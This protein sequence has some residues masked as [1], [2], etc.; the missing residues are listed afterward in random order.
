MSDS[1]NKQEENAPVLLDLDFV[2]AWARQPPSPDPYQNTAPSV[3]RPVRTPSER[4][5]PRQKPKGA[6]PPHRADNRRSARAGEQDR[7]PHHRPAP[8]PPIQV[9]FVPEQEKL[10][11]V[12][13]DIRASRLAFPLPEVAH[14]FLTHPEWH[15]VKFE[16]NK[17]R[18][19][20]YA[21]AFYQS[22]LSGLLF[23]DH[24]MALKDAVENVLD[25]LFE[26][27]IQEREAPPGN[28]VCVARCRLSG[29]LLPPTNHHDH[30]EQVAV[31]HRERFSHM[32]LDE[33]RRQIETV[34]DEQLIE[35]WKQK[36]R[37][38]TLY[39]LKSAPESEPMNERQARAYA[40]ENMASKHVATV[41][42][43]VLSG[44]VSRAITDP[45][46]LRL[47]R[48]AWSRE[49]HFPA[50]LI[51]ALRAAFHHMNLHLFEPKRNHY[52]VTAIPP[53]YVDPQRVIP[54]IRT[55]L[56]WLQQ[57]PGA[58]RTE[59]IAAVCPDAADD[60]AQLAAVLQPLAWLI[61]KGHVIE[62]HHGT[63]A[64]PKE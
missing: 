62:F 60:A 37:T 7:R 61:E 8:L 40:T 4:G 42:R 43:A 27:E 59:L 63:L 48:A 3:E 55:V 50:S 1:P 23:L 46:L 53:H 31:L 52:F 41:K 18:G 58:K 14:L 10:T 20:E 19:G 56:E 34:R 6:R 51:R 49:Q 39:R 17:V 45:A 16:S 2:P 38:Q 47:L 33:Y 13:S 32:T 26:K 25:Q 22:K 57:H 64:V 11:A 15:L 24:S 9:T 36:Y 5:R 35:E 29:A 12:A 54:S 30:A 44:A 28:F 21:T